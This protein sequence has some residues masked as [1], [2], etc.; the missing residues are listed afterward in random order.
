MF[1]HLIPIHFWNELLN[2]QLFSVYS[3]FMSSLGSCFTPGSVSLLMLIVKPL[4]PSSP[5]LQ[6]PSRQKDRCW[7][8]A[9]FLKPLGAFLSSL[10]I[11]LFISYHSC[12]LPELVIQKRNNHSSQT[13]HRV[14]LIS[15]LPVLSGCFR[16][17]EKKLIWLFSISHKSTYLI[18]NLL[19]S[20][21]LIDIKN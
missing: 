10:S 19:L 17:P 12:K 20:V 18:F 6:A 3:L 14:I 21:I 7:T 8:P 2:Q 13:V 4:P 9:L 5:F 1:S 15:S 16:L 11:S